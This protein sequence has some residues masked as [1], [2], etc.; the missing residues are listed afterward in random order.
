MALTV[1]YN[2][3][4]F[5]DLPELP[6]RG[7][8]SVTNVSD[9]HSCP[10]DLP[11]LSMGATV[12][13]SQSPQALLLLRS[14]EVCGD[15]RADLEVRLVRG[16]PPWSFT[17]MTPNG[18]VTINNVMR[19][20]YLFRADHAGNYSV[21]SV[22]DGWCT[23]N[24]GPSD[25]SI[26]VALKHLPTVSAHMLE[27]DQKTCQG[28]FRNITGAITGTP[29]WSL[30]IWRDDLFFRRVLHEKA[31]ENFSFP[32]DSPGTYTIRSVTDGR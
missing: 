30:E 15:Q 22:T 16:I 19:S 12:S 29:P 32:V 6:A 7:M 28:T 20:S 13:V 27:N 25:Q 24:G 17:L 1:R 31:A 18:M 9:S 26:G 2:E 10:P 8:W 4:G 14:G 23:G 5:H 3:Q 11:S 21:A